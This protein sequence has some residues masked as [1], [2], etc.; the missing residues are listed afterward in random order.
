[1]KI[2]ILRHELRDLSDTSFL[3]PLL[4][5]G[6]NRTKKDLKD[7]LNTLDI[8]VVYSSPFIRAL[9]TIHPYV[10]ENKKKVNI[11]YVICETIDDPIFKEKPEI[12]LNNEQS[13]F[14]KVNFLYNSLWNKELLKY[15]EKKSQMK[16]RIKMFVQYLKKNMK[17]QI[18]IYYY[19]LIC[20]HAIY[21]YLL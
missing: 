5:E 14:Y 8:N 16:Y 12:T 1:M 4:S 13:K 6:L 17:I 10:L 7:I 11:E 19:Q 18:R 20:G 21:Y 15:K 9:Q 2:Y 3:S